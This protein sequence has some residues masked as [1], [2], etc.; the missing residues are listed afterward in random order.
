MLGTFETLLDH[1]FWILQFSI[2]GQR[3]L[4]FSAYKLIFAI[5]KTHKVDVLSE[6]LFSLGVL[7]ITKRNIGDDSQEEGHMI[8]ELLV[9]RF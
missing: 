6:Y 5:Q 9:W 1:L 2:E 7:N 4:I 8:S 3:V